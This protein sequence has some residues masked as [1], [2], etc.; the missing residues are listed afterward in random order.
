MLRTGPRILMF[1]DAAFALARYLQT[2]QKSF[3]MLRGGTFNLVRSCVRIYIQNT[4]ISQSYIF[5]FFRFCTN[6]GSN[7]DRLYATVKFIMNVQT[8]FVR[9][10]INGGVGKYL[11]LRLAT[12][13]ELLPHGEINAA[14]IIPCFPTQLY[15]FHWMSLSCCRR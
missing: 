1:G 13:V 8:Y 11:A 3:V 15:S 2:M 12:L 10:W 4:T 6:C 7:L 5:N 9:K 14:I